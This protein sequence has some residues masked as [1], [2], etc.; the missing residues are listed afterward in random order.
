MQ[1]SCGRAVKYSYSCGSVTPSTEGNVAM[2]LSLTAVYNIF[3][4]STSG[5]DEVLWQQ[6]GKARKLQKLFSEASPSCGSKG[7]CEPSS[8]GTALQ[9]WTNNHRLFL[10]VG[11]GLGQRNHKCFRGH[12]RLKWQ[13][14]N[15]RSLR[16]T[17]GSLPRDTGCILGLRRRLGV[18][19]KAS[20]RQS[21]T[22]AVS[23]V[24][25]NDKPTREGLTVKYMASLFLNHW[26]KSETAQAGQEY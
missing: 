4:K 17:A 23:V 12:L 24:L 8:R 13:I 26:S 6:P 3:K 11:V 25:R 9:R 15:L 19:P 2:R 14:R 10:N 5:W 7:L 22:A 21:E 18:G 20:K 16:C 1:V